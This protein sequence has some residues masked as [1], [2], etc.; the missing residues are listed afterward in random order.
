M[1]GR[2]WSVSLSNQ[3]EKLRQ[4]SRNRTGSSEYTVVNTEG[5]MTL[6][7]SKDY[8][9]CCERSVHFSLTFVGVKIC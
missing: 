5:F 3:P 1:G 6:K 2:L 9:R 4:Y 7:T 8:Q